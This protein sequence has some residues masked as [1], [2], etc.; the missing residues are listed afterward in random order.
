MINLNDFQY[1]WQGEATR[2]LLKNEAKRLAPIAIHG[3]GKKRALLLL[4]GFSSSPA[5]FR[6]LWPALTD[7]DALVCPALPG[8]AENLTAFSHVKR[9]AWV[10]AAEAACK[11]LI[12]QYESVEI[13][14]LSLGGLL[15]CHLARQFPVERLYLL[16][17]ALKL[18]LNMKFIK[19]LAH[20]LLA[21]GIKQI[22]NKAG[23][24]YTK[25][26]EELAYKKLPIKTLL[27]LFNLI[28]STPFTAPPCR[29]DLFLGLHDDVVDSPYV[30]E[31]FKASKSCTTHWLDHSAHAIPLDGDI[32]LLVNCINQAQ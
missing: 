30:T 9:D 10:K 21:C 28:E 31:L 32:D 15:A 11:P 2:P 3:E 5:V 22:S 24:L 23:N 16:A 20:L 14:G 26:H 25:S 8:H 7:Y 1:M 29:T 18:R 12:E 27:E 19:S 4:H 6:A 17:P 13:V